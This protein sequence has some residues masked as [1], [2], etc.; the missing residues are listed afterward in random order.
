METV[1]G[2]RTGV[3]AAVGNGNYRAGRQS[4]RNAG[5]FAKDTTGRDGRSGKTIGT[6]SIVIR[7]QVGWAWLLAV[8]ALCGVALPSPVRAD[9]DG[10]WGFVPA[11]LVLPKRNESCLTTRQTTR[12]LDY[13]AGEQV[14]GQTCANLA[15]SDKDTVSVE[16]ELSTSYGD[17]DLE[18]G[19]TGLGREDPVTV[20]EL[21]LPGQDRRDDAATYGTYARLH[22]TTAALPVSYSLDYTHRANDSAGDVVTG[23]ETMGGEIVWA[24]PGAYEITGRGEQFY[25]GPMADY[26][27]AGRNARIGIGGP[28]VKVPAGMLKGDVQ[29]YMRRRWIVGEPDNSE[30]AEGV[31]LSVSG[32]VAQGL[33]G[34]I[35]SHVEEVRRAGAEEPAFNSGIAAKVGYRFV[36]G[37]WRWRVEPGVDATRRSGDDGRSTVGMR[38]RA[39]VSHGVH[40][41]EL[42][43]Y[44]RREILY[45]SDS[46]SVS[47]TMTLGYG[48]D[49]G[50][51]RVRL[52]GSHT[53]HYEPGMPPDEDWSFGASWGIPLGPP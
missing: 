47:N 48:Y 19:L 29:G 8:I 49:L 23:R 28:L 30:E 4:P 6:M 16:R 2:R 20:R 53:G 26:T 15:P 11:P 12:L 7:R 36:T 10:G 22:G 24:L 14:A 44:I 13:A 17:F 43:D 33:T 18:A 40:S 34:E 42:N 41:L 9:P 37:E 31:R 25:A 51:S 45:G 35:A 32:P 27:N 46:R 1:P 21:R 39:G 38:L 52:R 3:W 50:T 5:S